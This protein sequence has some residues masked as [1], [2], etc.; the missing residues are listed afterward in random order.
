MHELTLPLTLPLKMRPLSELDLSLPNVFI[1][2][3][4]CGLHVYNVP[5][6]YTI[7]PMCDS[8]SD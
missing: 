5:F 7:V 4:I 1:S 3:G 8:I 6:H 2:L